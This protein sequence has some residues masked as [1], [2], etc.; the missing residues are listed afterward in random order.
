MSLLR[1]VLEQ[2]LRQVLRRLDYPGLRTSTGMPCVWLTTQMRHLLL[3]TTKKIWATKT[4]NQFASNLAEWVFSRRRSR[5]IRSSMLEM[6]AESSWS[7][8]ATTTATSSFWEESRFSGSSSTT[9]SC[10]SN[11]TTITCATTIM[12]EAAGMNG[13]Q[14]LKT[15]MI[16]TQETEREP[17]D[18]NSSDLAKWVTTH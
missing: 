11:S 5:F 14:L 10:S 6:E 12:T 1:Q 13:P 9:T 18:N 15:P 7:R 8:R 17:V 3:G 16:L 4:D 2:V